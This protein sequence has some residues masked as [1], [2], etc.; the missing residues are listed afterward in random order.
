MTIAIHNLDFPLVNS[1]NF[2]DTEKYEF[3][4]FL[5]SVK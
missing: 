1:L 5:R 4:D 2:A 3:G